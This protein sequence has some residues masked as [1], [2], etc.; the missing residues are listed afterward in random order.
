M[1]FSDVTR[2]QAVLTHLTVSAGIFAILSYL[3]LFHWFPD[4]YFYLDGGN[5]AMVTIFV[6]DVV[7][8]PGLTLLVFKP[9]K[10]SLKFDMAV[11]LL[12]QLSA[13]SWGVNSVYQARPG[14]AVFYWGTLT[15]ISQDDVGNMDMDAITAGPGGRQRLS[16]L[17]RPDTLYDFYLF[18][19][20]AY[21]NASASIYYYADKIVPLDGKVEKRLENYRLNL[22]KLAEENAVLARTVESYVDDHEADME[23]IKLMPLSCRY[24][25]AVAVY[26]T[27]ELKVTDF[28][29]T[30]EIT[31][32]ADALDEP[33]PTGSSAD[34][35]A[36]K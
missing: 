2:K 14:G 26:D 11:I 30:K 10:K 17:Q 13:L 21:K 31:F 22:S 7:L 1:V 3:I 27:R 5:R 4:F 34:V 28:F 9:G 15:C 35:D 20:E 33:L 36:E 32:R 12:L 29:E 25:A 24:G 23:F 19:D 8:G 6:V 16:F 18:Q